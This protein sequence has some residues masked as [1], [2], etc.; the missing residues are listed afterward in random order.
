VKI[1]EDMGRY[2]LLTRLISEMV[3][4]YERRQLR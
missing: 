3:A 1:W 4:S 2:H